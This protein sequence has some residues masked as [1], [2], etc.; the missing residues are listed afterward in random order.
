VNLSLSTGSLYVY[1][2]RGIF[3]LAK[4]AGFDGVELVVGPEVVWRG[5]EEVRR[6]ADRYGLRIFSLHPPLFPMPGWR[7]Y[8]TATP[9]LVALAKR[10]RS[11]LVVLHPPATDD[12]NDPRS[13]SFLNALSMGQRALDTT[14]LRLALEARLCRRSRSAAG[15]GHSSCCVSGSP[16]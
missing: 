9:K 15:S 7:G 4:E 1:P 6:L 2:L 13:L 10:L 14:P 11:P 8:Q 3:H 5:G 12:W 16:S